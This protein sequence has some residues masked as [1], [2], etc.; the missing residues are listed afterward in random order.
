MAMKRQS[1][2]MFLLLLSFAAFPIT[3]VYLAPAPPIM[4]RRAGVINL[5]VLTILTVFVSGFFLRR[6]FCGW[7]CPGGGCQLVSQAVND[8]RFG[9]RKTN[10][11][12]VVIVSVWAIVMIGAVIL[13][14]E[15]SS[16]DVDHPGAGVFATSYIRFFLPYIPVVIFIFVFV[17]FFGRRGFCHRGCWIYPLIALSTHAG[18]FLRTPSLHVA[19]KRPDAC[20]DCGK[21]TKK[22]SMSIDV[23]RCVRQ[24]DSLPKNCIQ[25]GMCVD[26]CPKDVLAFSF[27]FEKSRGAVQDAARRAMKPA[28]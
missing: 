23:A 12:R 27:G 8:K 18:A 13:G 24:G 3:V 17:F 5:S 16:L 28:A 22:C 10:W 1:V 7:L 15:L 9:N 26:S 14:G 4:S 21:C 6:A 2:R 25:C 20:K 19:A 11:F